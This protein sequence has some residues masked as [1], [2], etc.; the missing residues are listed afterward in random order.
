MKT[1]KFVCPIC[2]VNNKEFA[3]G[4]CKSCY[5]KGYISSDRFICPSCGGTSYLF[6]KGLCKK[7]YSD[8]VVTGQHV[9]CKDCGELKPIVGKGRCADCWNKYRLRR[10]TSKQKS[11]KEERERLRGLVVQ[12]LSGKC[13]C[14]G[15]TETL[16]LEIDHI[17]G[18]GSGHRKSVSSVEELYGSMLSD[19]DFAEKYRLLCGNCH[20]AITRVGKCPH[21]D[22]L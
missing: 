10:N 6:A 20:N 3:R 18:G 22:K 4:V 16:F 14:C 21:I 19:C 5:N 12:K 15:E 1:N 13:A 17:G 8:W 7:C 9:A 11:R 2:G